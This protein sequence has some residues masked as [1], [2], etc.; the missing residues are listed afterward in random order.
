MSA[1]RWFNERMVYDSSKLSTSMHDLAAR[2]Y[3]EHH[4]LDALCWDLYKAVNAGDRG[5]AN[6]KFNEFIAMVEPHFHDEDDV[7]FVG[8]VATHPSLQSFA[9]DMAKE[10]DKM[11][12]LAAEM[13]AELEQPFS[14]ATLFQCERL[15]RVL[16][17]HAQ[18]EELLLFQ[19]AD[20]AASDTK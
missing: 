13:R 1:I 4:V 15:L 14:E 6:E 3:R 19:H 10:H 7:L 16:R 12:S 5:R 17:G 9:I 20:A 2:L 18:K 11:R 8:V